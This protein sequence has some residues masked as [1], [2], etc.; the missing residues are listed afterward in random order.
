MAG[1]E[2]YIKQLGKMQ[3]PIPGQSLT[4]D[5][6]NPLPFEGP[7]EF[8]KKKDALENLFENMI[9]EDIYPKMMKQLMEG[10]TIMDMTQVLLFEGFR[11]GKWNPDLLLML[12][13]PT[14]Y[15]IMALAERAD[16]DFEIDSEPPDEDD[17]TVLEEKFEKLA[18]KVGKKPKA[19]MLPKDIEVQIANLPVESLLAKPV[20][21]APAEVAAAPVDSLIQKPVEEV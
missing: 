16:V 9:R 4:N 13:E 15:M 21:K 1:N 20:A 11:Q 17:D 18:K 2:A 3:R 19:G 8:T 12:I 7:P 6:N 14:A 5:P 10:T